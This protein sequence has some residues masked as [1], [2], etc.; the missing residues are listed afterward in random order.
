MTHPIKTRRQT[1]LLFRYRELP[2]GNGPW[3][4]Y[5]GDADLN[6]VYIGGTTAAA[7][8]VWGSQQTHTQTRAGGEA[9]DKD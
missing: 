9:S 3:F 7:V 2:A 8:E 4:T 5:D 1:P 6:L